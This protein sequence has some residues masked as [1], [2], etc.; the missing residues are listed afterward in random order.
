M[1]LVAGVSV[2]G[3]PAIIGDLLMSWRVPAPLDLPTRGKVELVPGQDGHFASGLAQKLIIVRPWFLIAWA[4]SSANA[5]RIIRGLDQLLPDR[6]E[7]F[8]DNKEAVWELLSTSSDDDEMLALVI[9]NDAVHPIGIRTR[10]FELEGKRIYLMGSGKGEFFDYLQTHP[11][12]LPG[13]ERPDGLLARAMALRFGARAMALQWITGAGLTE[14]WGGG[15]EVAY[16]DKGQVF[17]KCDRVLYRAWRI[18]ADGEYY[19]SGRSFFMRYH[20]SD[21]Y[22]SCFNPEEK[23]YLVCS[24]IGERV[25]PPASERCTPA[26]TIDS[27]LHT[28]TASFVEAVRAA[29]DDTP[30]TDFFDL[31]DGQLSGWSMDQSYVDALVKA[32]IN[33]AGSGS[34]FHFFRP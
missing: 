31:V 21:L 32:A 17:R 5:Q 2:G 6:T 23:T 16:P 33:Q 25:A 8:P 29:R 9:H 18:D 20:G 34:K 22:L 14:S 27:F 3:M 24:P 15:F 19:N 30:A 26:W 11:E 10:G 7:D 4:G 28:P 13:Q 12:V 1:T